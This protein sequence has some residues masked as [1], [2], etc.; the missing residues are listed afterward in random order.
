MGGMF[1]PYAQPKPPGMPM[2]S[3]G[4]NVNIS[5]NINANF[6]AKDNYYNYKPQG[7]YDYN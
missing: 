3:S 6:A 4:S 2:G 5:I 1:Y 7:Y